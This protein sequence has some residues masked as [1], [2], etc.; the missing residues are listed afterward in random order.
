LLFF[1]YQPERTN[2]KAPPPHDWQH[3]S[4]TRLAA[5]NPKGSQVGNF[6]NLRV[7][8]KDK[9]ICFS[10]NKDLRKRLKN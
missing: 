9:N 10:K 3:R 6:C 4:T 5:P 2:P 7:V 8:K 1:C